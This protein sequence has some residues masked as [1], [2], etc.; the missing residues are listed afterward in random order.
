MPLLSVRLQDDEY[1][2]LQILARSQRR[3]TRDQLA[4]LVAE[5]LAAAQRQPRET[6]DRLISAG[7]LEAA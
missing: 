2:A 7:A 3:P 1:E 4:V 5:G 6:I